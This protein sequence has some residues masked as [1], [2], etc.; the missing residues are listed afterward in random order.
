MPS[1]VKG[2]HITTSTIAFLG[3][4]LL[5]FFARSIYS[6]Q[7]EMHDA[8]KKWVVANSIAETNDLSHLL[9]MDHHSSRWGIIFPT[10]LAIKVGGKNLI[11]YISLTMALFSLSFAL[12]IKFA[13]KDIEPGLLLFFGILLFYE[14]MFFR[15][16]TQLQPF[17][18]G[19]FY[20]LVSIWALSRFIDS[21]YFR[22]L[23][24]SA[25]FTF[26]A[27]GTKES[28]LFFLPG[29]FI[30]ILIRADFKTCCQYALLLSGFLLI[31]TLA[32]NALSDQLT[33]G[34]IDY[35]R[36]GKHLAKM[37]ADTPVTL[38][39][40]V[41]QQNY[42]TLPL[43]E[44][45]SELVF[46]RWRLL[47]LVNQFIVFTS[48]CFLVYLSFSKNY[49]KLSN[50]SLGVI[51]I[52][53]SYSFLL[54]IIPAK[55]DPL[56]PLQPLLA[57]YL[58]PVMPFY[59]YIFTLSLNNVIAIARPPTRKFFLYGINAVALVFLV[60]SMVYESPLKY[61]FKSQIYPEKS[62]M[63]WKYHD[64]N[65]ALMSGFGVCEQKS[66]ML[67][68]VQ[69]MIRNY[70]NENNIVEDLTISKF[71]N[72]RVLH[73]EKFSVDDL[74]GFIPHRQLDQVISKE[75]CMRQ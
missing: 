34:R 71:G 21:R 25:I 9:T 3:L 73:L 64:L 44:Q 40:F 52:T 55:I 60:Y 38:T 17:V 20:M 59:I 47:P 49:L 22:F 69:N 18:F 13:Q 1:P 19:V 48:A 37:T 65:N 54:S 51:L 8:R 36:A 43:I 16:S 72:A 32:F 23:L 27:Y 6:T 66:M 33:F 35:L 68:R 31:E 42:K 2:N 61:K 15:A 46:R 63:L 12:L 28:Y 57:K 39:E 67:V 75:T 30:L 5:I 62:A 29:L 50:P 4:V 58:I 14:P 24:L 53:V 41:Y 7:P 10:A 26:F 11:T 74:T 45:F 70:M 56:L